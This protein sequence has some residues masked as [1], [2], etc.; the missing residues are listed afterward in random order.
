[1]WSNE[2]FHSLLVGVEDNTAFVENSLDISYE[3]IYR[4]QHRDRDTLII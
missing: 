3:D 1:M 4:Y 2:D